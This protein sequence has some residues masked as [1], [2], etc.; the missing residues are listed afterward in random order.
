MYPVRKGGRR[1]GERK[2]KKTREMEER[3]EVSKFR[4]RPLGGT[5]VV[6]VVVGRGEPSEER[7]S[8]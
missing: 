6:T 8:S 2:T 5:G 3:E 1:E 4:K 7:P